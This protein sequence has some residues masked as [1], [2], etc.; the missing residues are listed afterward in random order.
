MACQKACSSAG[1][2][3]TP[4][5]RSHGRGPCAASRCKT[6][7]DHD[8]AAVGGEAPGVDQGGWGLGGGEW[9][10]GRAMWLGRSLG[11]VPDLWL[12]QG[13]GEVGRWVVADDHE[14]AAVVAAGDALVHGDDGGRAAARRPCSA[15]AISGSGALP[16]SPRAAAAAAVR[17]N[18]RPRRRSQAGNPQL[19]P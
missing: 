3:H 15:A 6:L 5:S 8:Q 7:G 19:G 10:V 11:I 17:C 18:T 12:S 9:G 14:A 13:L 2:V 4:N 1:L 16:A